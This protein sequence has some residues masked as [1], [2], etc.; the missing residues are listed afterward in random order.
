MNLD[1]MVARPWTR[2]GSK[3]KFLADAMR[4]LRLRGVKS[5]LGG[6]GGESCWLAGA[7]R[8]PR[9]R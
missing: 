9:G 7:G 2:V 6:T 1:A 5:K 8:R 3:E 4:D